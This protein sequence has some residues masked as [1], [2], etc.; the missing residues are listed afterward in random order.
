MREK[1]FFGVKGRAH[2]GLGI[3]K[4]LGFRVGLKV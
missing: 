2:W 4:G 1:G 3:S